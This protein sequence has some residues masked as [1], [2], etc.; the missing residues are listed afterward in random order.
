MRPVWIVDRF[1]Q[2]VLEGDAASVGAL[3]A[4]DY[5]L[6]ENDRLVAVGREAGVERVL[7][8]RQVLP[9][10]SVRIHERVAA[11]NRVRERWTVEAWLAAGT[12]SARRPVRID[13]ASWTVCQNGL[14]AEVRE[15]WDAAELQRQ[16]ADAPPRPAPIPPA[17]AR[18]GAR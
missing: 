8:H 1:L 15:W 9:G 10:R 11:G 14:I 7:G 2:L 5:R 4:P 16:L 17:F 3:L 13:G 12:G 6:Y 18:P